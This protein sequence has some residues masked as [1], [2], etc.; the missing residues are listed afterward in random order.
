MIKSSLYLNSYDQYIGGLFNDLYRVR[1][2]FMFTANDK[3][4]VLNDVPIIWT[5]SEL[6]FKMNQSFMNP[7]KEYIVSD[8]ESYTL[9][10]CTISNCA[11]L[12]LTNAESHELNLDAFNL[13]RKIENECSNMYLDYF[14]E[15]AKGIEV[16]KVLFKENSL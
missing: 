9:N 2:D 13:M 12:Y 7:S 1:G 10:V 6:R 5:L 3:R 15:T 14:S 11:N 16:R 4:I 8:D